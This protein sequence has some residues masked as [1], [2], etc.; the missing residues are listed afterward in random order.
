MKKKPAAKKSAAR[1]P[2]AK[3]PAPTKGA[4]KPA[5]PAR[6]GGAPDSTPAPAIGWPP[7]R[8]PAQ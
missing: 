5:A 7:F 4:A 6:G 8:Y 3:K 1:K 2:V